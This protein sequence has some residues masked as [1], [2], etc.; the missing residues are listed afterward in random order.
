MSAGALARRRTEAGARIR[1]IVT[2]EGIPGFTE[3]LCEF[4]SYD[5]E[6]AQAAFD[7][8]TAA[9]NSLDGPIPI[10]FNVDQGHEPVV[11][12]MVDNLSEIGI[13]AEPDGLIVRGGLFA[14]RVYTVPMDAI[15]EIEPH[16]ELVVLRPDRAVAR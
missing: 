2:P 4:C 9:G 16:A 7:E 1:E 3:G 15:L 13:E 6:A 14:N 12:I 8:W 5:P 10:Q 11:S